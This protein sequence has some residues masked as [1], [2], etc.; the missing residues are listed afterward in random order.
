MKR[1]K[2]GRNASR[3]IAERIAVTLVPPGSPRPRELA[4]RNFTKENI[5]RA[6]KEAYQWLDGA[7]ALLRSCKG[8]PYGG[9]EEA[10]CGAILKRIGVTDAEMSTP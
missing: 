10:L 7:L 5:K 3:L 2:Y 8:N 6:A 1:R 4:V 9:D